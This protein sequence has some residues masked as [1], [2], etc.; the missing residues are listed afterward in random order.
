MLNV[1]IEDNGLILI[2]WKD[3]LAKVRIEKKRN[4]TMLQGSHLAMH[5]M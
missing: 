2:N 4:C 3:K 5:V 1:G